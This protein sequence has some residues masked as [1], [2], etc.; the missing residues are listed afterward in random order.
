MRLADAGRAEEDD[1]LGTLDKGQAGELMD[2]LA[3]YAG[4]EAKVKAVER[5]DR[6][7][8]GNPCEHLAGAGPARVTLGA[9]D[10]FQKVGERG[11]FAAARCA[12]TE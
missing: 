3:R 1:V 8:A 12:I 5:L 11:R 9:Q 7:E 4:G 2:L 6:G 10:L